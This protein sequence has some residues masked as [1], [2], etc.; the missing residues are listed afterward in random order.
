MCILYQQILRD[1]I[2]KKRIIWC[3]RAQ[4]ME[5]IVIDISF[6]RK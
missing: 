1:A 5:H 4:K 2:G 3:F 6:K